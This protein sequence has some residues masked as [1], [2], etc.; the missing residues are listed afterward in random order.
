MNGPLL[1]ESFKNNRGLLLIF[2]GVLTMYTVVMVF[3]YDPE[4]MDALASMLTLFPPEMMKAFGFDSAITD[5]TSYLASWLYGMLMF[6]FPM[7]YCIILGHRLVAKTVDNGSMGYLLSAPLSRTRLVVTRG[8]YAL[9]SL[10]ALFGAIFGLTAAV[11]AARFPGLLNMRGFLRLV[12]TTMLI[13]MVIMMISFFFSCLFNDAKKSL[14]FGSGVPIAFFLMNMLGS[15]ADDLSFLRDFSVYGLHNPVDVVKNGDV[16]G[17]N[18]LFAAVI[19]A[20]FVGAVA[21]FRRKRLPL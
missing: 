18:L 8:V 16:L 3:M 13:N 12:V 6:G 17:L 20:L 14:G 4:E 5:L 7:V 2:F 19:V 15:A 9:L 1:K 10:V 11:C 21:V